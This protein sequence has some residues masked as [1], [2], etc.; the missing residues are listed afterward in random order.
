MGHGAQARHQDVV[1]KFIFGA[2][3]PLPVR[4]LIAADVD[5]AR[6]GYFQCA[7]KGPEGEVR[8]AQVQSG[9]AQGHVIGR[10]ETLAQPGFDVLFGV[11]FIDLDQGDDLWVDQLHHLV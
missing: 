9:M 1:E 2:A 8:R 5:L 7:V 6:P 11:F 3:A 4:V 10:Q